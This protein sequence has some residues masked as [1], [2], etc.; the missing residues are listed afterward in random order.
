[1]G[2]LL[3]FYVYELLPVM[4]ALHY[5]FDK[6]K[7]LPFPILFVV[8]ATV[9]YLLYLC[10]PAVGPGYTI[11]NYY[12]AIVATKPTYLD[13]ANASVPRNCMP[14]LHATWAYFFLWNSGNFNIPIRWLFRTFGLLTLVAA[15][16][17]LGGHWFIDLVV[18][19]P[20]ACAIQT[21]CISD[22]PWND[23]RRS[24]VIIGCS[25]LVIAWLIV[26]HDHR[27]FDAIPLFLRWLMVLSSAATPAFLV[28]KVLRHDRAGKVKPI[29]AV[30]GI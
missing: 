25:V 14:S 13:T 18:A 5:G 19:L 4:V 11:E 6:S 29:P 26:L 24:L 15:I 16:G 20:F 12:N 21:I 7:R 30:V 17:G 2:K 23:P 10:F 28:P 1:M 3:L 22:L 9:G 8:S 27:L